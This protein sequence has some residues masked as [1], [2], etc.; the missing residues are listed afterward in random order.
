MKGVFRPETTSGLYLARF[1]ANNKKIYSGKKVLDLGC[2]SGIQG[3][4]CALNG[5]LSVSF[6]DISCLAVQNT[7]L[8]LERYGLLE[9]TSYTCSDLFEKVRGK[10]DIILFNHPFFAQK[11]D[12]DYPITRAWF[13]D[14]KLIKRFLKKA[15]EYLTNDGG[16][17]MPF[18]PFAGNTNDPQLQGEKYGFK[19]DLIH[20]ENIDDKNLQKGEFLVF[21]LRK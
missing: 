21:S 9:K 15:P 18:F 13:D 11:P 2:G 20:Q 10:F 12:L 8:N 6:S 19:V 7:H 16:V 17:I 4:T 5:A 14:G 3:I 1:L